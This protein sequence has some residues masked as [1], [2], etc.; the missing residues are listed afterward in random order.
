MRLVGHIDRCCR[1]FASERKLMNTWQLLQRRTIKALLNLSLFLKHS[2]Y[3]ANIDDLKILYIVLINWRII[4]V[5]IQFQGKN[6]SYP[7]SSRFHDI[8]WYLSIAR[9]ILPRIHSFSTERSRNA[10]IPVSRN[11]HSLLGVVQLSPASTCKEGRV[12]CTKA[13]PEVLTETS[14]S[15]IAR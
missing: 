12:R 15:S 5:G 10:E 13:S 9:I 2:N 14:V 7:T 11:F 6:L 1:L 4:W 8:F 3:L